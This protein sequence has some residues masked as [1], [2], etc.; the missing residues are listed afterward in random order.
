MRPR[1][2]RVTLRRDTLTPLS[3]P[4]DATLTV[5]QAEIERLLKRFRKLD[6]D[7]SGSIDKE[8]FLQIPQIATNPLA[9]R[10]IAIFD[11][12]G[13]GSVDFQEFVAGLS[14]FS[15]R[16]GRDEKLRCEFLESR[17]REGGF[18]FFRR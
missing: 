18:P 14:A 3:S 16:G 4:H 6:K 12:D 5:S 17:R 9:S 11:E 13:G 1:W 8:E 10:M 15:S 7:G 2:G